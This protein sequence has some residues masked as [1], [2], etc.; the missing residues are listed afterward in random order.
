VG[1]NLRGFQTSER[2]LA[3]MKVL[4]LP[5]QQHTAIAIPNKKQKAW[6]RTGSSAFFV[7]PV[8][9]TPRFL[10]HFFQIATSTGKPRFVGFPTK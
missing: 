8:Q 3:A 6:K 9:I 7:K 2:T 5:N 10:F 4:P 1:G